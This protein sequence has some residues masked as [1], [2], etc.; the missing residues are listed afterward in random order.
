[1]LYKTYKDL[2]KIRESSQPASSNLETESFVI[3]Q[4]KKSDCPTVMDP[5]LKSIHSYFES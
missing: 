3:E 4:L 2:N 5:V 1:M